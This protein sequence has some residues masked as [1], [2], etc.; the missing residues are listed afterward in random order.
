MIGG[1]TRSSTALAGGQ[2]LVK[3]PQL[4]PPMSRDY[5]IS[6]FDISIRP[7][8]AGGAAAAPG[9]GPYVGAGILS[10][11]LDVMGASWVGEFGNPSLHVISSARVLVFMQIGMATV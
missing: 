7:S 4:S 2:T 5:D 11:Q 9:L 6:E 1:S 8:P 10:G 3:G